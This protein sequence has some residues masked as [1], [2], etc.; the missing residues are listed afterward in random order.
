MHPVAVIAHHGYRTL[1]R[2]ALVNMYTILESI[3]FIGLALAPAVASIV[4]NTDM[5]IYSF[6]EE[7]RNKRNPGRIL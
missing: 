4:P 5:K 7:T 3:W 6:N 2:I 1:T